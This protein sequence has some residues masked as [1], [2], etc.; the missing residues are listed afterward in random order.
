MA[1]DPSPS[2]SRSRRLSLYEMTGIG[3]RDG[4]RRR[5]QQERMRRMYM[6]ERKGAELEAIIQTK[7]DHTTITV[8][9]TNAEDAY[10]SAPRKTEYQSYHWPDRYRAW[11]LCFMLNRIKVDRVIYM[12]LHVLYV[13]SVDLVILILTAIVIVIVIEFA[14]GYESDESMSCAIDGMIWKMK[15]R[16]EFLYAND[17]DHDLDHDIGRDSDFDYVVVRSYHAFLVWKVSLIPYAS[18]SRV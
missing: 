15:M 2:P 12:E 6:I 10:A 11:R 16:N 17:H 3:L 14:F 18:A 4:W 5:C 9:Q 8:S 13:I 1:P 7:Y